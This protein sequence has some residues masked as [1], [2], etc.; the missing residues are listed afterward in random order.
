VYDAFMK[1]L[2]LSTLESL[3]AHVL[4]RGVIDRQWKAAVSDIHRQFSKILVLDDDPTGSQTV[5]DLPVYTGFTS[6]DL[7]AARRDESGVV[8]VLTN[9]RS[10]H[11]RESEALHRELMRNW[12]SAGSSDQLS[13]ETLII[14]RSDS[15]LRGHYPLETAVIGEESGNSIHGEILVPFFPEGGRFTFRDIHYVREGEQLV[16]ASETEFARDSSFGYSSSNLRD[17]VEEKTNGRV[18]SADVVSIS[19]ETLRSGDI[20]AV[21]NALIG[22]PRRGVAVVN[23]VNYDDLKIFTA[24]LAGAFIDGKRFIFRAAAALV[25]ILAGLDDRPLL[26]RENLFSR[27]KPLSPEASGGGG[28]LVAGSYV[29]KTTLQLAELVREGILAEVKLNIREALFTDRF[30]EEILRCSREVEEHLSRGRNVG[31][32]TTNDGRREFLSAEE[33]EAGLTDLKLS[34]RISAGL[35]DVVSGLKSA[36]TWVITKG[37]ITSHDI[38]V[39][40]MLIKRA[41]V[42]GQII[43]GVPVWRCGPESRWPGIPLVIFPGNVGD[44]GALDRAAGLLA[45][46]SPDR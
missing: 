39:K 30:P 33:G 31:I 44:E 46:K 12:I 37:G 29:H 9:S 41:M 8:Y 36:P 14:S 21:R 45:G 25:K 5:Y 28:I 15:T 42:L 2:P 13:E 34:A 17:Y 18:K 23:A 4:S 24:A 35:V 40:A 1:S 27:E 43:P 11:A 26:T 3:P 22:I 32:Y 38:S 19:L 20:N 7:L 10:L 16:P 6:D